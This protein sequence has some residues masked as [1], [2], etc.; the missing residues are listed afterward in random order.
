MENLPSYERCLQILRSAGCSSE[1]IA[2]CQAVSYLAVIIARKAQADV[3]LV[4][5]GA[6]LHDIGRSRTQGMLHAVEGARIAQDLGLPREVAMI[7]ER[8]M[9]AGIPLAEAVRLGL[10]EKEYMPLTLEEK[11]VAHADNL[12]DNDHRQPIAHEIEK[13]VLK[14]QPQLAV[15]LRAL[16]AELSERCGQDLDTL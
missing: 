11:I 14:G 12:I 9:G 15:R 3:R 2:H 16:H 8:H 5:V 13:A 10:P 1:V 4:E 6:L 7:I